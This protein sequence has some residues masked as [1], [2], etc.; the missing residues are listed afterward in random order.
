MVFYLVVPSAA[1]RNGSAAAAG[2][3]RLFTELLH[4][5]ANRA[6]AR[7]AEPLAVA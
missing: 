1:E 7:A 2:L 5:L 3:A 4:I 6:C